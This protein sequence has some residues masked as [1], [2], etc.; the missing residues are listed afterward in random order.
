MV[1]SRYLSYLLRHH[2]EDK[3][4]KLDNHGWCKVADVVGSSPA[5]PTILFSIYKYIIKLINMEEN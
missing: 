3:G 2:P 5:T 4:L 1:D